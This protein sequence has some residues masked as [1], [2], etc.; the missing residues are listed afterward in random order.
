[1]SHP[2]VAGNIVDY[3]ELDPD[4]TS[5]VWHALRWHEFDRSLLNPMWTA[6]GIKQFYVDEVSQLVTGK[7]AMA[8]KWV[9]VKGVVHAECAEVIQM[10][11][12]P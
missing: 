8:L 1:M 6:D 5:E 11:V 4:T 2:D 10:T 3:P 7:F 9:T 12:S